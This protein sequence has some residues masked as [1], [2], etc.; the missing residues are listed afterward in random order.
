MP[1]DCPIPALH[2]LTI[3]TPLAILRYFLHPRRLLGTAFQAVGL[4]FPSKLRAS[5]ATHLF[6]TIMEELSAALEPGERAEIGAL[7]K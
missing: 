3:R 4:F 7:H 2:P 6:D 1:L 5:S